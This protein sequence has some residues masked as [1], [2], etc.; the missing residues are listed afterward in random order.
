VK[1]VL[2]AEVFR[3]IEDFRNVFFIYGNFFITPGKRNKIKL[4]TDTPKFFKKVMLFRGFSNPLNIFNR[5]TTDCVKCVT[6]YSSFDRTMNETRNFLFS[7]GYTK[8]EYINIP[9]LKYML[10]IYAIGLIW[11][12]E[13]ILACQHM[14]VAGSVAKWYFSRYVRRILKWAIVRVHSYLL[15]QLHVK[16]SILR[17]DNVCMCMYVEKKNNLIFSPLKWKNSSFK[18][19]CFGPSS[20]PFL[21]EEFSF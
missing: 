15:F 13:F 16:L 9:W 11:I 20:V 8:V 6:R 5:L 14:I 17:I 12:S 7:V 1:L 2:S 18:N 4:P 21:N 10:F 3:N 19:E